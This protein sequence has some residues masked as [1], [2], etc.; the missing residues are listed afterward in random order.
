[1][2]ELLCGIVLC[3]VGYSAAAFLGF[4]IRYQI[5]LTPLPHYYETVFA[6]S[7]YGL[8]T[9]VFLLSIILCY[10]VHYIF[11]IPTLSRWYSFPSERVKCFLC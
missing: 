9:G 8:F 1:M 3:I 10:A 2:L 11:K 4:I 7:K 6:T 5:L